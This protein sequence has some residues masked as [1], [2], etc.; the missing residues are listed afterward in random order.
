MEREYIVFRGAETIRLEEPFNI[1][2]HFPHD[3]VM[4][5]GPPGPAALMI[6]EAPHNAILLPPTLTKEVLTPSGVLDK[7]KDQNVKGIA[8]NM[9]TKLIAPL[10]TSDETDESTAWGIAATAANN[11][12][13][14]GENVLVSVLDTGID[15][16]HPAF[17]GVDL[18]EKDF[19]GHGNGDRNGHGTHCAGTLF[20]RNVDGKRIGVAT[21]VN[22]ALIGK[23]LFHNETTG[24]AEGTSEML[25]NGMTWAAKEGAQVISMSI[26][27]DYP[28]LV[29]TLVEANYPED[30]AASIA[31]EGYRGNLRMFDAIMMEIRRYAAL[32]GK[33]PVVVAAAGNESKRNIHP[34][35]EVAVSIPA[36]ADSVISVGALRQGTDG[37]E[38]AYFS[39][40]LPQISAPGVNIISAKTGGG[41]MPL[42]G[43][44]MACPHVAGIT[45][46]W[47]EYVR[48]SN[49]PANSRN[50]SSYLFANAS[51]TLLAP[52]IDMA[53][54]GIGLCRAPLTS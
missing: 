17:S 54:C 18:V 31:L 2:P 23:V 32:T 52:N 34:D 7:T 9:P 11:S 4:P 42:D 33:D 38:I 43:T 49:I 51:K 39:N 40:T 41:L 48:E 3:P 14:T 27:F 13:Y 19:T 53:D 47:W 26:G 35:Y 16:Q 46:L 29:R 20:G 24:R 45:A 1:R 10:E 25:F 12:D 21:G 28:G 44:S 15:T 8:L 6:A 36:A 30:L 22:R 5:M 50:V 37:L